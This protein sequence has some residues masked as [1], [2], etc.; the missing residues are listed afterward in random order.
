MPRSSSSSRSSGG[1]YKSFTTYKSPKPLNYSMSSN[2]TKPI[3]PP[4]NYN[5]SP[6]PQIVAPKPSMMD[7]AKEGF[8]FGIGQSVA[9][10]I[11]N[12][13]LPT[14]SGQTVQ[15]PV[16]VK[17]I[18]VYDKTYCDNIKMEYEKCHNDSFCSNDLMNH[19]ERE[20]E[21]CNKN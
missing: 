15:Q 10:N 19:L 14:S 7:V 3:P 2:N 8:S 4:V 20:F 18:A 5:P 13:I 17:K 16:E 6:V 1:S 11:I 12:R 21:K 9:H